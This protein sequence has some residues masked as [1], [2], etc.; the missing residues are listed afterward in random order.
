MKPIIAACGND[1][2]VCPRF[3]P[4]TATELKATAEL[5]YKIGFRDRVVSNDEIKCW[6]CTP[7]NWCRHEIIACTA[8]RKIQNCGEC[9]NYPCEKIKQAFVNTAR[10]VP[11]Y[12]EYCTE[13]EFAVMEKA[14][15]EKQI[16]LDRLA[17][18]CKLSLRHEEND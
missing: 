4:K 12:R 11:D 17:E 1:C 10:F 7:A 5:W 9:G 15:L 2:S 6:G 8:N 16:N 3:M 13:A 14:F 18:E